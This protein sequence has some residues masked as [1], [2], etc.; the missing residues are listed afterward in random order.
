MPPEPPVRPPAHPLVDPRPLLP[1]LRIALG[2]PPFDRSP[3]PPPR[4]PLGTIPDPVTALDVDAWLA[5][6]VAGL[7]LFA[8]PGFPSLRTAIEH[9]RL[10]VLTVALDRTHDNITHAANLLDTSR[11]ALRKHLHAAGL[12]QP[13]PPRSP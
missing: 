13:S 6:C 9:A 10:T 3:T 8:G 5:W 4:L 2:L 12:R 7:G 1:R 11:Q